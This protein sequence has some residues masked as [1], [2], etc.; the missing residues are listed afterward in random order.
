MTPTVRLGIALWNQAA[1][2]TEFERAA[3]RADGLGYEH[4]WTWDHLYAI[5]GDPYQPVFEGY[6][7]LAALS[8]VTT[9]ARL[10]LFVGANTFRN[11]GIVAKALA[12]LDHVSAGRAIAGL[13]AAWNELEHEAYGIEFGTSPGERLRWLDEAAGAVRSLFEGKA[14]TSEPG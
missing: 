7:A 3:I 11:P 9:T 1:T 14:V 4:V 8:K 13:G 10:G 6:T 2:W 12:T 5:M